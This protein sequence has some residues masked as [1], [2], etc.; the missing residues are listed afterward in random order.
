[1]DYDGRA[2]VTAMGDGRAFVTAMGDD[3]TVMVTGRFA[4]PALRR[5]GL[6]P[7]GSTSASEGMEMHPTRILKVAAICRVT[8]P[9]A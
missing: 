4:T 8:M 5:S 2:F 6:R 1:M 9:P 7:P 3:R